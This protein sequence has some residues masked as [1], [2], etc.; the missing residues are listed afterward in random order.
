MQYASIL[1]TLFWAVGAYAKSGPSAAQNI[2][3]RSHEAPIDEVI[4]PLVARE[5]LERRGDPCSVFWTA[6]PPSSCDAPTIVVAPSTTA[7]TTSPVS[8]KATTTSPVST[9]ATTTSPVS[10][11][12]TTTSPVSTKATTTSPVS[13]KA[14]TTSPV[15]TK[16]TTTSPVSTKATTTSAAA[17]PTHTPSSSAGSGSG[18]VVAGACASEGM[19]N[20]I[21]GTTYQQCGSGHWSTVVP[22][23]AGTKCT[24]GMNMDLGMVAAGSKARSPHG[25]RN[26]R[27]TYPINCHLHDWP[28][29]S[30]DSIKQAYSWFYQ[31]W[32]PLEADAQ[33]CRRIACFG[34]SGVWLCADSLDYKNVN[35]VTI[36]D[37]MNE[38]LDGDNGC[39]DKGNKNLVQGQVSL[40]LD[41][42]EL[43]ALPVNFAFILPSL[44]GKI[45]IPDEYSRFGEGCLPLSK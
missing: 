26:R 33:H 12:A 16:A 11:K 40:G 35:S 18:G 5:R 17:I 2:Q 41:F 20:C 8:T 32:A 42:S 13:T 9:K 4:S 1:F 14:T 37:K 21:G 43:F 6:D 31:L 29:A 28:S 7:T 15:S 34:D 36:A 30:V 3:V 23:P 19:W 27:D 25:H 22:M 39:L 38:L 10:T 44:K 45:H 24:L